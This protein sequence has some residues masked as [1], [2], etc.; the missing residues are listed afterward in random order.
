MTA[1]EFVI[2]H[3][4]N[5]KSERN[6]DGH[7]KGMSTPYWLIRNGRENMYFVSSYKSESNAWVLAKQ[8]IIKQQKLQN[9]G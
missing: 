2:Q 9:N 3:M 8:R 1:K 7:I 4:P 5:A 6:V